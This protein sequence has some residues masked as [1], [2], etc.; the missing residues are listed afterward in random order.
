MKAFWFLVSGFWFSAALAQVVASTPHGIVVAHDH[1]LQLFNAAGTAIVWTTEGVAMATSIVAGSERVAVLDAL[2]SS[3]RVVE[4]G[5]G[6][7]ATIDCGETPVAG[8]FAG[9]ALYLLERDARALERI[10]ADGARASISLTADPAFLHESGDRLY[11]YARA[12]GL[13]QE[14][15]TTPFAVA[16]SAH[17]A[18]FASDFEIDRG[19]AYF[20]Y[21]REAKVRVVELASMKPAGESAVGAVPV[22]LAFTSSHA[23]AIADPSAKRVWMIEGAESFG[24]AF[25]RGFLRGLLGLGI[26]P[27][28]NSDF[29]TGVDRVLV[30]GNVLFA[31]DTSSGTLYRVAQEKSTVVAKDVLPQSFA[32]ASDSVYVWDET[33]RRLQ[34][35]ADR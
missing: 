33:V 5:N 4:L 23:L 25:A 17:V 10:G 7:G 26:H 19:N 15:T 6:R 1:Q 20:V 11:V 9:R 2:S 18:P 30:R 29:P 27:N 24:Q 31:Y 8:V 16:R 21:P 34:R 32:V 28:R 22:A 13:L 12:A 14:I 35:F 3:V